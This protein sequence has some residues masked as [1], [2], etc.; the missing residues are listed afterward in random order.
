M[1]S[2][3]DRLAA[4][5][6]VAATLESMPD[7]ELIALLDQHVTDSVGI[8]GQTRSITIAA[9]PVFVKLVRLTDLERDAGSK[10]TMNLFDLPT[11]YQY[12]VGE[13][14]TGFNA[15]REVAAHQVA[16]DWV[17]DVRCANFP[18]LYHWRELPQPRPIEAVADSDGIA[19]AVDFWGNSPHVETRLRAQ[20]D[21]S[22]AVGLFLEHFPFVLRRWLIEELTA[23]PEQAQTAITLVEQQ[24]LGAVAHMRSEGMSHFDLH[25]DNVLTDGRQIFLSDF[26]LATS[27]QFQ[28][29]SSER[30][31]VELTADHDLAYSAATLVN[32]IVGALVGFSGPR[33]RNAFVRRCALRGQPA[34]LTDRV[35]D[36]VVRYAGIATLVNDFYW[37]LHGGNQAA[38]Y[39]ATEIAAALAAAGIP[40]QQPSGGGRLR[41]T[42]L[43]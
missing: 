4:Q 37:Q 8:G 35:G 26:G 38:D 34:D 9:K 23:A 1:S 11:W 2:F 39:P 40:A 36:T 16:S 6:I 13:G 12:G 10:C 18:L 42:T 24:L 3:G 25:Y 15:W 7:S 5:T 20:A 33:E 27:Q 21:S 19:R 17:V 22:T 28:L 30:H 14:S 29:T 41:N 31:F 43:A 32:T